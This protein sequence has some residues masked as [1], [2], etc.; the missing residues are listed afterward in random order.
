[1]RSM[2]LVLLG[3]CSFG[4]VSGVIKF[5]YAA[6]LSPA[7]VTS[8]QILFGCLIMWLLALMTKGRRPQGRQWPMLLGAGLTMGV[9]SLAYYNALHHLDASVAIV[10]LFQFT[11]IG[12]ILD[13]VVERRLPNRSTI[14]SLLLLGAGTLL[15]AGVLEQGGRSLSLIGVGFGLLSALSYA[16]M[17]LFSGKV[18]TGVGP[19]YRGAVMLT[20]SLCL[21]FLVYRPTFLIDGPLPNGLLLWGL[22][23]AMSASVIP[24][25]CFAIGVPK[26]GAG[27]ATILGAAELPMAVLVSRFLLSESVSLLQ[28]AGGAVILLAIALPEVSRRRQQLANAA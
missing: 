15:A 3:S 13:A 20:G 9:T 12:V 19:F 21:I 28:W 17:I 10:M 7:A 1:M 27:M 22:A 25:I 16:F 5:A 11:W 6:G 4:L 26:I 14:L 23:A 8:S 2:L 18:A 24:T